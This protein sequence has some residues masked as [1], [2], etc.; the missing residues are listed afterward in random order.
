MRVDASG[1]KR[2]AFL[3]T[4]YLFKRASRSYHRRLSFEEC[5]DHDDP[6]IGNG[7]GAWNEVVETFWADAKPT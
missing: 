5:E 3:L 4:F 7:Q 2:L 6:R 1:T